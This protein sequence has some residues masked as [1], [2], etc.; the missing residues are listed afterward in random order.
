MLSNIRNASSVL[1]N[2]ATRIAGFISGTV[3]RQN[4]CQAVAPSTLAAFSRSS[5]TRDSPAMSSNAMNGVVF[6]ISARMMIAMAVP[7]LVNGALL[8]N[9]ADRYP[10][11]G[12]HAYCQ[13]NAAT[14]VTIP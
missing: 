5:G 14:I 1:N 6:Q 10:V 3:I 4:R 2:S 7:V 12:V 13:L 8:L 11:L 9:S